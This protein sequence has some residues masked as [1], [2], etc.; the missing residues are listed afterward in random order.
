MPC[1]VAHCV[2][3]GGLDDEISMAQSELLR[4]FLSNDKVQPPAERRRLVPQ[5]VF[6]S[7]GMGVRGR[8]HAVGGGPE[9]VRPD[10]DSPGPLRAPVRTPM[11]R[12]WKPRSVGG[13]AVDRDSAQVEPSAGLS[14]PGDFVALPHASGRH[15][16][17][18]PLRLLLTIGAVTA[19]RSID[20]CDR[21]L[22]GIDRR[23]FG[24]DAA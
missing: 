19:G 4:S 10:R 17:P 11:P 1:A 2:P 18:G 23:R 12:F 3:T 24:E 14:G 22:I 15:A 9:P 21:C 6:R 16:P 13:L 8:G 20:Y 7:S 5:P